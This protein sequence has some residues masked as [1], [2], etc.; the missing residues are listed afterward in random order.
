M[1]VL[2]FGI[3]NMLFFSLSSF[4]ANDKNIVTNIWICKY[5]S[6]K[7][8]WNCNKISNHN[9]KQYEFLALNAKPVSYNLGNVHSHSLKISWR[10]QSNAYSKKVSMFFLWY[11]QCHFT[12]N[13]KHITT[14]SKPI[15]PENRPKMIRWFIR[16]FEHSFGRWQRWKWRRR[17]R[18]G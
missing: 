13:C 5:L 9:R 15:S 6:E 12:T 3:I 2:F 8:W 7:K 1:Q 4:P 11:Y 18:Q 10:S 16:L 17:R 14:D